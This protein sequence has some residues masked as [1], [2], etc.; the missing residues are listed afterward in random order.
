MKAC[1]HCG[2][3]VADN[4]KFCLRCGRPD[5]EAHRSPAP[6]CPPDWAADVTAP[7][8]RL[9]PAGL[10]LPV[11]LFTS[12]AGGLHRTVAV[13]KLFALKSHLVIGRSPTCDICLPHPSVSRTHAVLERSA[14]GIRLRDLGS[15][16]GV[17]VGG[18]R[19]TEPVLLRDQERI[20]IGPY[21]FCLA[22]GVLHAL[23]SSQSVRLE[24]QTWKR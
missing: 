5:D 13:E 23:D 4:H 9:G 2:N 21:L 6:G 20:G 17:Q 10:Q 22:G 1:R 8:D 24:A 12:K 18:R 3:A 16:N 11:D 14:D 15:V 7:V 19:A